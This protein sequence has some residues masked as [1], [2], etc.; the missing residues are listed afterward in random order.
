MPLTITIPSQELFDDVREEFTNVPETNV[1]LEHSLLSISKWESKWHKPYLGDE[2]HTNDE[3]LDYIRCMVITPSHLSEKVLYGLTQDNVKE[4][5]NY[6]SDP[7]T[8]TT[9]SDNKKK[10][11]AKKKDVVTS[12]LIYYWMVAFNIPVKFE[13]W[14]LNRLLTLVKICQIENDPDKNK[15]KKL[16]KSD[17]MRRKELNA[18]RRAKL[19]SKG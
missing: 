5:V 13:Q 14:H 10:P 7:M 12:E 19:N 18:A 11:Q 6:I 3:L 9:F 8:A 15:K 2:N 1:T 17:L 16:T 4:I